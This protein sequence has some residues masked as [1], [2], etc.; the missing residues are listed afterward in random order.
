LSG[1]C[2]FA[3]SFSDRSSQ[4]RP[5]VP[6]WARFKA[7]PCPTSRATSFQSPRRPKA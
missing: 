3:R 4:S 1:K 2:G 7:K 6:K 5:S